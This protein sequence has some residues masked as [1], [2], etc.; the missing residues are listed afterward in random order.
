MAARKSRTSHS[1]SH[2]PLQGSRRELLPDSR[3]AG[4]VDDSEIVSITIRVRSKRDIAHLEQRVQEMYALPLERRKYLS[5]AELADA[6]GARADD[7]DAIEH[8]AHEH[9]L[10]VSYR[11]A[12]ERTI[13]L[14]G[15]LG[16]HL[17][18]FHAD[19]HMFHHAQGSYR[20]R[21]GD[22][23]VP[24][25]FADLITGIFG[26]DNRRTHKSLRY[27]HVRA[28]A[29]P[30]GDRG[31][32][33]RDFAKHYN[34]PTHY[35]GRKLDGSGQCIGI[36]ELGGGF[37]RSELRTYF[38][39]IRIPLPDIASVSVNGAANHPTKHGADDIEVMMDVEI[40]G[41]VA[42]GAKIAVYFSRGTND[43]QGLF[44]ALKAAIHDSER[45]PSVIATSW[46]GNEDHLHPNWIRAYHEIFLEAAALGITICAVTGDHGTAG[47]CDVTEWRRRHHLN[48]PAVDDLVLACGGTQKTRGKEVVWN[49]GLAFNPDNT[50]DGWASGGGVSDK[51]KLPAYQKTAR[52]PKSIFTGKRGRGVPDIAMS[53]ENYFLR[54]HNLERHPDLLNGGTSCVAPLMAGLVALLNQAKRKNVGF[55]NSFLYANAAKGIV[56]DITKGHNGIFKTIKGYKARPGWDACTGL[57]TPDG[58]AILNKL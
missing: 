56:K 27:R 49:D 42:P 33:P 1:H 9:N 30:G 58:T 54:W 4:P 40:A 17:R 24:R 46:G 14:T 2:V 44:D 22:I 20:G 12:P 34:F 37:D 41:A 35:K 7:L 18:A 11:S 51:F 23:Y 50:A 15:R 53:A 6:C 21:R 25:E 48:H 52:V 10:M 39:E 26:F 36:I 19:L 45:N 29:A 3:P 32:S 43:D 8:F 57:G 16:N 13:T 31:V 55:L 5:R 28:A 38:R 47:N